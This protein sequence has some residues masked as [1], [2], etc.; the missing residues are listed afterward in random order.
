MDLNNRNLDEET[1]IQMVDALISLVFRAKICK[2]SIDNAQT[3]G[4]ILNRLEKNPPVDT[5]SFWAAITDGNGKY[6]FPND[7]QFKDAL[8]SPEIYLNLKANTCKYLLY[9]LEKNSGNAQNLPRYKDIFVD[10]V[11]PK[12]LNKM[13]KMYLESKNRCS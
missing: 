1:F 9:K 13:W 10:Y 11:M 6:T 2:Q 12:K 3:A 5:D 8:K 4:N 7:K